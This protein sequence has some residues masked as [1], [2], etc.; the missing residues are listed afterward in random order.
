LII[1]ALI[2]LGGLYPQL[3]VSNRYRAALKLVGLRAGV[4]PASSTRLGL[5]PKPEAAA[6]PR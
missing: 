3:G 2:I 5:A 1:S 6:D 4:A